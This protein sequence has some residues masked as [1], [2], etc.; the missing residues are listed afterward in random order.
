MKYISAEGLLREELAEYA[1]GMAHFIPEY[2][3]SVYPKA[4]LYFK[5]MSFDNLG[6]DIFLY[7]LQNL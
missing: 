4:A 3:F 1:A 6:L 2:L 7:N 5:S